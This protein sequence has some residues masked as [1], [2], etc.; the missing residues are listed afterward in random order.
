MAGSFLGG[1][2]GAVGS[3]FGGLLHSGGT[4]LS[5][6]SKHHYGGTQLPQTDQ[7][8]HFA[9]V[10]NNERVLS[11]SETSAYN[12]GESQAQPNYIVY[13]PTVKAMDSRDVAQW[14]NDNK[15][16]IIG[17]VSDGIK[18]NKQGIRT[19]IQGV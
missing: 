17:I 3:F 18:N 15:Q 8:E 11:P 12:Q 19:Q 4:I 2:G 7:T 10:K 5:T 1:I 14:F 13:A 16:Q 9:L 6:G